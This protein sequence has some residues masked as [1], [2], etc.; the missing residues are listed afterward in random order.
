MQCNV[1]LLKY[2]FF[3]TTILHWCD[4]HASQNVDETC[5]QKKLMQLNVPTLQCHIVKKRYP[6]KHSATSPIYKEK[7]EY[8]VQWC[9]GVKSKALAHGALMAPRKVQ[10]DQ[11]QG[12]WSQWVW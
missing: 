5:P 12:G 11:V 2:L 8:L 7:K 9:N 4:C 6:L 10:C 1:K 3:L